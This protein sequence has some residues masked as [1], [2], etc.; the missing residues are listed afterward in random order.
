MERGDQPADHAST[1]QRSGTQGERS[2]DPA[3][4]KS[5]SPAVASPDSSEGR[6]GRSRTR[7]PGSSQN[8]DDSA[9]HAADRQYVLLLQHLYFFPVLRVDISEATIP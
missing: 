7:M 6:R 2:Y 3:E 4:N 5:S 8:H 1:I 9:T